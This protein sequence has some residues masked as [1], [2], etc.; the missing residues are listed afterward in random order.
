MTSDQSP[1]PAEP[2]ARPAET[3]VLDAPG[4]RALTHP[5]RV[6]LLGLLRTGGP[7]TA[8]RLADRL[9]LNSGATSY[10]LRQ[11]AAAGFVEEDPE[12]PGGR[13]RWWRA[14]HRFTRFDD[15]GLIEREPSAALA[16]LQSVAAVHA[17][18]TQQAFA[19]LPT[20]PT[21]WRHA[22][23][24]GDVRLR[25][26]PEEASRLGAELR[27]VLSRYPADDPG[28]EQGER[29][30][31]AEPVSV[32]VHVLPLPEEPAPPADT[33]VRPP[34]DPATG[35]PAESGEGAP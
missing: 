2:G 29:R 10:H 9:D 15:P 5:V 28:A 17:S 26:T 34:T 27:E 19:H 7:S 14:V 33:P 3:V 32:V 23:S 18:Q 13:E 11:L 24:L 1:P 30:T 12:R 35:A 4:L 25:L 21:P 31:G 8:T 16:Y 6:R 20:S 22:L